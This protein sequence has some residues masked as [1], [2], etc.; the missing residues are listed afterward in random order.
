MLFLHLLGNLVTGDYLVTWYAIIW[1]FGAPMK[2]QLKNC[3]IE[4][5]LFDPLGPF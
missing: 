5:I 1:K 3:L 2:M 4:K